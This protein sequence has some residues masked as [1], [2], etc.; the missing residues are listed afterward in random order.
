MQEELTPKQIAKMSEA[1]AE[2][3]GWEK[4]IGTEEEELFYKE[5]YPALPEYVKAY[6][7]PLGF[8]NKY[9]HT[10]PIHF[11]YKNTNYVPMQIERIC[12]AKMKFHTSW[13]W[14]HEVWENIQLEKLDEY[15]EFNDLIYSI[16]EAILHD[17]NIVAF[18]NI[19]HVIV[20]IN[21]LKK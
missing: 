11:L 12:L 16:E 5:C 2:Y 7:V 14:I 15:R 10:T 3:I 17:K 21:Q 19:Y 6:K 4:Y 13:D 9:E 20:F 8:P 18:A 1:V